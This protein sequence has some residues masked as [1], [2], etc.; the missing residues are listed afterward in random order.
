MRFRGT[1][2]ALLAALLFAGAPGP[3]V[4]AAQTAPAA[5]EAPSLRPGDAFVAANTERLARLFAAL[6]LSQPGLAECAERLKAG[7]T[8]GACEALLRYYR[9]RAA[10]F[11]ANDPNAILLLLDH[12][13]VARADDALNGIFTEQDLR[14]AALRRP[15]GG[16]D[17]SEAPGG[18]KEWAWFLNRHE[19]LRDLAETARATGNRAYDDALSAYL[20]DWILSNPFPGR[21]NF[22]AQ[23]RALE[24]ARRITDVWTDLFFDPYGPLSPEARLLL[25]SSLPDHAA[26]LRDFGSFWGGNHRLT[27]CSALAGIAVAWP[28]F[29]DAPLW[30]DDAAAGTR[31]EILSGSYPD[32]AYRELSSHYQRVVLES[33]ERT[34]SLLASAGRRNPELETRAQAMWDYFAGITQPDGHGP[35]NNDGDSDWNTGL[36]ADAAKTHGRA[37]WLF[38]ASHGKEGTLPATPPSRFYPYAGHAVMRSGWDENA[39]WAYFDVGPAGSAHAHADRLTLDLSLGRSEILVDNG[40][41]TYEPGPWKEFFTGPAAHNV[42]LVDGRGALPPPAAV[43]APLPVTAT[44]SADFDFFSAGETFPADALGGR[45][46]AVHV[47]SVFYLRGHFWLVADSVVSFGATQLETLWHFHPDVMASARGD[48]LT[49]TALDGTALR[50]RRVFGP[51]PEWTLARGETSPIQGWYSAD[52][53]R[54]WPA[55]C[56]SAKMKTSGPSCTVWLLSPGGEAADLRVQTEGDRLCVSFSSGGKSLRFQFDPTGRTPPDFEGL[57]PK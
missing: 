20:S 43:D 1:G 46:G 6:D 3:T 19:F 16:I 51:A 10:S 4:H 57:R 15:D 40:R 24:A 8:A 31:D 12:D 35:L 41:F 2:A 44:I 26:D 11:G 52:Y 9:K 55:W 39:Q 50:I 45:G 22:S 29:R 38:V 37:D 33:A 49:A 42:V 54:R 28:E 5:A 18:D 23:W 17:W 7:D 25:L 32:G 14:A 47:R 30:L 53:N 21:L 27:E 34:L 48:E 56:A 13:V 36:L